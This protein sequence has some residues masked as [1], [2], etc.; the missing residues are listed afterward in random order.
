MVEILSKV[1]DKKVDPQIGELAWFWPQYEKEPLVAII[2][3]LPIS[4]MPV[5]ATGT[6]GYTLWDGTRNWF[7]PRQEFSI[8]NEEM[9]RMTWPW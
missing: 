7:L 1:S 3:H 2:L 5:N 9:K 8:D 4:D 6:N